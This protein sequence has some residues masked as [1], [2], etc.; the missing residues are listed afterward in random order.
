M[1]D[2]RITAEEAWYTG[3]F[4]RFKYLP[5]GMKGGNSGS[6][7]YTKMIFS[8]KRKPD[9]FGKAAQYHMKKGDVASLMTATGGGYGN[10]MERPVEMV[11]DDLKNGYITPEIAEKSYGIT[12]NPRTFEVVKLAPEREKK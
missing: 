3:T 4:G 10:P 12:V 7:N 1:R 11:I 5:W 8:D 6:R 2:Y 9:I